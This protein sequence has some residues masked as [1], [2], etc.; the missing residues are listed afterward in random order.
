MPKTFSDRLLL[1]KIKQV[2]NKRP[3]TAQNKL[4]STISNV[5][6]EWFH[7][8]R[9]NYHYIY[10]NLNTF[11]PEWMKS[12]FNPFDATCSPPP[13]EFSCLNTSSQKTFKFIPQTNKKAEFCVNEDGYISFPNQLW[14]LIFKA[15]I[16]DME[17]ISPFNNRMTLNPIQSNIMAES[18]NENIM[19]SLT[20]GYD[21]KLNISLKISNSGATAKNV[22]LI[23]GVIPHTEEGVGFLSQLQYS[24]D[25]QF[26]INDRSILALS[27]Q[28][29]NI[30]CINYKDGNIFELESTWEMI[31]QSKC[32]SGMASGLVSYNY[33]LPADSSV[34]LH[35]N[36]HHS[37][38]FFTPLMKPIRKFNGHFK[39]FKYSPSSAEANTLSV[40]PPQVNFNNVPESIGKV[41]LVIHNFLIQMNQPR[42]FNNMET[43]YYTLHS[44]LRL[45]AKTYIDQL[46]EDYV[47][48][49]KKQHLD[50]KAPHILLAA[51][52]RLIMDTLIIELLSLFKY[53]SNYINHKFITSASKRI[54]KD[55]FIQFIQR[56]NLNQFNHLL[57]DSRGYTFC[58]K[59]FIYHHL[60]KQLI[61]LKVDLNLL[62]PIKIILDDYINIIYNNPAKNLK[63][64]DDFYNSN[65]LNIQSKLF[66]IDLF[67]KD[68]K[69]DN[70]P[71]NELISKFNHNWIRQR[72]SDHLDHKSYC[73]QNELIYSRFNPKKQL[74]IIKNYLEKV[75]QIG[76]YFDKKCD[77]N[78]FSIFPRQIKSFHHVF[79]TSFFDLILITKDNTLHINIAKSFN[80][81]LSIT[82]LNT[83]FGRISLELDLRDKYNGMR[84]IIK[85]EFHRPPQKIICHIANSF[86]FYSIDNYTKAP[87]QIENNHIEF[88]IKSSQLYLY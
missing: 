75:N 55:P 8:S 57:D 46:I 27:D 28:P 86:K 59:L 70:F 62:T 4:L 73:E 50:D 18:I 60:L 63:F 84:L 36:I 47:K 88:P 71:V 58:I 40:D 35:L 15:K 5:C 22:K 78:L 80:D 56:I 3:F 65:Q 61:T 39:Q 12:Q 9:V 20:I 34:S 72:F 82:N 76:F 6:P 10:S 31:L 21:E 67:L 64:I 83:V 19:F 13:N 43:I 25:Q 53:D 44:L 48:T 30:L 32:E 77:Y 23:C 85:E 29:D 11:W 87:S 16:D 42:R 33:E 69:N 1:R 24:S 81:N 45:G 14:G 74:K 68:I 26:I 54:R 38:S 7:Q 41:E 52:Q 51:Q 2:F 49:P 17:M 66:I 37:D 79:I